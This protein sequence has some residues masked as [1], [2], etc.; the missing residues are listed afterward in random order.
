MA[1]V[2]GATLFTTCPQLD[3]A[4]YAVEVATNP[5]ATPAISRSL[6]DGTLI[7][8]IYDADAA[9]TAF[10][11][12]RRGT[13]PT[14]E[15]YVT[16]DGGERLVPY[17]A[18]NNLIASGCVLLPSAVGDFGDKGDLIDAVRRFIHRYVDLSP[19]FEEIA[20]YYVLLTW[21]FDAF[22]ELGYLRFQGD[23][24]SGKTR[25]LLTVGSV[26]YKPFFASGASTVSPIFHVLDTFG[27]TLVLDEAD[28]RFTDA[29]A[30]LTKILNNG[31]VR[32]LP[33]LR[34]MA[35]RHRELN[36]TAFKVFGPKLVAM[37]E[38]FADQALESRFLT[39]ETGRRSLRSDIPVHLPEQMRAEAL[40]LRN[41]LL[42]WR[43]H[44]R[45]LVGPDPSRLDLTLEPRFNQ[46][47]LAL[48][49]IVD[50]EGLRSRIHAEL[51]VEASRS[52]E[53]QSRQLEVV[54][55]KAL[56]AARE[57]CGTAHVPVSAIAD[58]FNSR[59]P[60]KRPATN[61]W[62]GGVLRERF[63][64]TTRKSHGVYVVP[65]AELEKLAAL[66]ERFGLAGDSAMDI[67]SGD[68]PFPG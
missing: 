59:A 67:N 46:T 4:R 48:L 28:F 60:G 15:P 51:V 29:T 21:V 66:N 54:M 24:G 52:R 44:A 53:G 65:A 58:Q 27:G 41:R 57:R 5:Q 19:L 62:V 2:A 30:E 63:R 33:V 64:L 10:A 49:S 42:A 37:R 36:P 11:L 14:I 16:L 68:T 12:A 61:R 3:V 25:A 9:S 23:W 6:P 1:I 17:S 26:C 50:D 35:N 18:T 8:L 55:L 32:G 13:A 31:T 34:T 39:E 47:A 20:A 7:E 22:N 43:F 40:L 45:H 38:D 56:Q